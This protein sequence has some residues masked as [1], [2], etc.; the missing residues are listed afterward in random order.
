MHDL[1]IVMQAWYPLGGRGHTE[2]L[3]HDE[4]VTAISKEHGVSLAQVITR[5]HLQRGVVAIPGSSNPEHILEN[6]SVFNFALSDLEMDKI[7]TLDRNEKH[8]WY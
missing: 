1:G 7:A 4:T 8:K 5:R 3:L 2:E 6:V